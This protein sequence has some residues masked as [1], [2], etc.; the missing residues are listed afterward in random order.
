MTPWARRITH[1]GVSS[2]GQPVN[3][4]LHLM[5]GVC[6]CRM[7]PELASCAGI[8]DWLN[9]GSAADTAP[10]PQLHRHR[11]PLFPGSSRTGHPQLQVPCLLCSSGRTIVSRQH[12]AVVMSAMVAPG[13]GVEVQQAPR[14]CRFRLHAGLTNQSFVTSGLRGL[15]C[16]TSAAQQPLLHVTTCCT[17][18]GSLVRLE[19]SRCQHLTGASC[20]VPH[21]AGCG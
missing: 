11:Q 1:R 4:T 16:T 10:L 7:C 13:A 20:V 6:V 9:P 14:A 2:E 18:R 8:R 12:R 5:P 15:G 17:S 19:R 21:P 3:S